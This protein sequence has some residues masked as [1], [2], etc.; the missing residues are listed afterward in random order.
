MNG[1]SVV[2]IFVIYCCYLLLLLLQATNIT[3]T[4]EP[5][6]NSIDRLV[7]FHYSLESD[8]LTNLITTINSKIT[9]LIEVNYNMNTI[10]IIILNHTH[11]LISSVTAQYIN[12]V[13]ISQQA[14]IL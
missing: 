1:M 14:T 9:S 4:I 8:D 10:I 5:V 11:L 13:L 7:R 12:P 2:N 6:Y 3:N